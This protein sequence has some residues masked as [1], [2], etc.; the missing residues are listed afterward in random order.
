MEQHSRKSFRR[1]TLEE[2]RVMTYN[3]H[4]AVGTDGRRSYDRVASV[5]SEAAPDVVALQEL[6]VGR[7]RSGKDHQARIIA[8]LL[9]MQYHFHPAIR[10]REEE[11][12]DAVLSRFPLEVIKSGALPAGPPL[13]RPEPRGALWVRAATPNGPWHVLNTHLGLGRVERWRQ[14]VA[15]CGSEWIGKI[16]RRERLIFCGDLNSRP[17]SRV[18]TLFRGLLRDCHVSVGKRNE[19]TFSTMLPFICLDYIMTSPLVTVRSA[20]VVRT[21]VSR[22]ASDH[23]PVLAEMDDQA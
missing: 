11:Y 6:D 13:L 2:M 23:F 16:D 1:R 17:G 20:G 10:V 12:G 3:V 4:G 14:A 8:D 19:N 21:S 18:H 7:A 15:L 22:V 9:E 5:V